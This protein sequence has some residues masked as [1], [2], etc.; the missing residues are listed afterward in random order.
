M[1]VSCGEAGNSRKQLPMNFID[2]VYVG[3][4]AVAGDSAAEDATAVSYFKFTVTFVVGWKVCRDLSLH[5]SW[6]EV[7]TMV[8]RLCAL[9]IVVCLLGSTTNVANG[10]KDTYTALVAFYLA[11]RL[12]A[13][14]GYLVNACLIPVIRTP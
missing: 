2:L 6:F 8:Q 4:V 14:L 3:V 1:K 11:A 7:D 12:F 5:T 10:L 13:A 9:F